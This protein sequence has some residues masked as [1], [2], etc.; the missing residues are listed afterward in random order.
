MQQLAWRWVALAVLVWAGPAASTILA[1]D[2]DAPA[3]DPSVAAAAAMRVGSGCP[4]V[5]AGQT[6]SGATS[7]GSTVTAV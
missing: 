4:P 6:T 1:Q 3:V 5:A 2:A 7:A